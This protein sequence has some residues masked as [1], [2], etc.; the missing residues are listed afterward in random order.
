MLSLISASSGD[1][2]GSLTYEHSVGEQSLYKAGM[3]AGGFGASVSN[4]DKSSIVSSQHNV[5]PGP[6]LLLSFMEKHPNLNGSLFSGAT[7]SSVPERDFWSTT[8]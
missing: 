2:G 8:N 7:L 6:C 3:D 4:T 5:A 1:G